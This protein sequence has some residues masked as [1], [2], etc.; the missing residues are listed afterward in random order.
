MKGASPE[1]GEGL[2]EDSEESMDILGRVFGGLN[3]FPVVCVREAN[4][5][6]I[7]AMSAK[8]GAN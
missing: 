2:E 1:L 7:D 5:N 8:Y 4:T 3:G 6:P